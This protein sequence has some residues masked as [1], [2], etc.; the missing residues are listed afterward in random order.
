MPVKRQYR[1]QFFQGERTAAELEK[2]WSAAGTVTQLEKAFDKAGAIEQAAEVLLVQF[3]PGNG[4]NQALQVQQ[5][6]RWRVPPSWSL[7]RCRRWLHQPG[8]LQSLPVPKRPNCRPENL[9]H[10]SRSL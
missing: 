8:Q 9:S 3:E 1:W 2:H 4:F 10:T 5:Q 7:M 6:G